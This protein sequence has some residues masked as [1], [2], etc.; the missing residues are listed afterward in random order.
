M[1][2]TKTPDQTVQPVVGKLFGMITAQLGVAHEMSIRGHR[3][4]KD[5]EQI[6]S[7]LDSVRVKLADIATLVDAIEALVPDDN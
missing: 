7:T 4:E 5:H 6:R 1:A 3:P 2:F